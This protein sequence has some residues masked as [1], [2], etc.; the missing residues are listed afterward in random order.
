MIHYFTSSGGILR[1]RIMNS[2]YTIM[3]NDNHYCSANLSQI[4]HSCRIVYYDFINVSLQEY[5]NFFFFTLLCAIYVLFCEITYIIKVFKKHIYATNVIL[6]N[7]KCV[8]K[9]GF[10]LFETRSEK[11]GLF[12]CALSVIPD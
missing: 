9:R 1:F 6:Y 8:S 4:Y 5:E 10:L 2:G 11:T 12:A 3:L 7:N